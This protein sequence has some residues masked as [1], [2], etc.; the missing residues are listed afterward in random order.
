[1]LGPPKPFTYTLALTGF[2][3]GLLCPLQA[4][5]RR[6]WRLCFDIVTKTFWNQ[7][8]LALLVY[9]PPWGECPCWLQGAGRG[10]G[11]RLPFFPAFPNQSSLP[12]HQPS[13]AA[14][15]FLSFGLFALFVEQDFLRGSH[16]FMG[17]CWGFSGSPTWGSLLIFFS[18]SMQAALAA[19][20][21]CDARGLPPR[22]LGPEGNAS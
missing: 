14:G 6:T 19:I 7:R 20:I 4:G 18:Q 16:F 9:R 12:F 22:F 13:L 2:T 17:M 15:N 5:P 3:R 8:P 1:M 10:R 21:S 11:A